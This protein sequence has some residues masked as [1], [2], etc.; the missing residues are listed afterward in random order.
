M[1]TALRQLPLD[2][3]ALALST[4]PMDEVLAEFRRRDAEREAVKRLVE[5]ARSIQVRFVHVCPDSSGRTDPA[6]EQRIA[7]LHAAL[8]AFTE[9]P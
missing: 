8:T 7:A 4:L 9:K 3:L 2:Q 1:T 6:D 5:A